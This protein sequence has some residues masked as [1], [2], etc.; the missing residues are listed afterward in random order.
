VERIPIEIPPRAT[1]RSYLATKRKKLGHLLTV[2][3]GQS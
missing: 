3:E 2:I 1:N